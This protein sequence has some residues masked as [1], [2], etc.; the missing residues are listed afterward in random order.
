MKNESQK[1]VPVTVCVILVW[2][3]AGL[4]WTI[5]ATAAVDTEKTVK[6]LVMVN[7]EHP[8]AIKLQPGEA[9]A[10]IVAADGGHA[11][12][13][14]TQA[15]ASWPGVL[16]EPLQGGWNLSAFD[17]VEMDVRNPEDAAIR[18]LL[19]VNNPGADGRRNCNV[20][21]VTVA[22]RGKAVL[23]VPFGMW[24]GT[25]GHDLD[26]KNIVSVKVMLDRPGRA[27]HFLVDNIRAASLDDRSD[28]QRVIDDPF[29]QHL[30][31]VF[32]R[33][34]NL[35]NALEAPE[36][37]Q[38]GVRLKDEYFDEIAG[39]G[40]DS[41]R[42]PVRWSAHAQESPPYRIDAKFFDRVDWA[43]NQALKR[44]LSVVVN[45]HH[46]DEIFDDP[47]KHRER[48]V[49]MWRQ[50]ARHYK[51]MPADVAFEL[52]NE[53]HAKL[54]PEKWN[55]I[56]KEAIAVIRPT[57][58]TRQI[59]VG[60][61]EWN[62]IGALAGLELPEDDR[63][64]IV[65]VHYYSPFQF[66]HQGASWAG[67]DAQGWLGTKWTGS[68]AERQAVVRDLDKAITWAVEH[69]RPLYLGEFGA[70][71]KADMESRARWTA[72]VAE[73]AVRRKM[74]FA[75]WEFCSGFGVFDAEKNQWIEPLKRALLDAGR[76]TS[77]EMK[78]E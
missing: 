45:M 65:T 78:S 36:E 43:I 70:Y 34:V 26:L 12:D 32:G 41:V 18:V 59:V 60:P 14:T 49:A 31:P 22:P 20:E 5:D 46:Y 39:A 2:A 55:G 56:L 13:I 61:G 30:K 75:Y 37:G 48:F 73:E 69:R 9:D 33:G 3:G 71:S 47:D 64:L 17:C 21:S 52:L 54:T 27:H 24:H 63:R 28:M 68:K 4:P 44:H 15:T 76:T 74:G 50:I 62:A 35:G 77:P 72:F 66:T 8:Q 23:V 29:F 6:P 19:S 40:F 38:W 16:I 53:P 7:F 67:P 58:T 10:K 25:G 11:L 42:I 1:C 51:G 57:N